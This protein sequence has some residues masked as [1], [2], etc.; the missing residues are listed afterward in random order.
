MMEN[1][2]V[3]KNNCKLQKPR[4]Y[5]KRFKWQRF[6]LDPD[7]PGYLNA[8]ESAKLAGY[9]CKMQNGYAVIGS[10]LRKV[11]SRSIDRYTRDVLLNPQTIINKFKQLSEAKKTIFFQRDGDV[12]DQREVPALDIQLKANIEMA[13]IEGT[14]YAQDNVSRAPDIKIINYNSV[15]IANQQASTKQAND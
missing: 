7:S 6:Y 3:A 5:G 12:T 15:E 14:L 8:T 13:K 2:A 9:N 10:N 1:T 11:F 4:I